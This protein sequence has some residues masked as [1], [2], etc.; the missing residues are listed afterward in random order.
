MNDSNVNTRI[1]KFY[2]KGYQDALKDSDAFLNAAIEQFGHIKLRKS[3]ATLG[4]F[5]SM[6]AT[7]MN[8]CFGGTLYT[9][10][11]EEVND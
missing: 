3:T 8:N 7:E 6:V 4:D 2:N 1:Q 5:L 9:E 10:T 11:K